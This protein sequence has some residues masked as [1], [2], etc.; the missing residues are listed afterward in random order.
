MNNT[1]LTVQQMKEMMD[2]FIHYKLQTLKIGDFEVHKTHYESE[3]KSLNS[4]DNQVLMSREDQL[5]MSGAGDLPPEIKELLIANM[6][7]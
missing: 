4:S 5:F 3:V 6:T 1:K 2:L 7:K